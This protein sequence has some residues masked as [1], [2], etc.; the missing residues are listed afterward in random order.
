LGKKAIRNRKSIKS[1]AGSA[2]LATYFQAI[3]L[4]ERKSVLADATNLKNKATLAA[5]HRITDAL[6]SVLYVFPEPQLQKW[7]ACCH[8]TSGKPPIFWWRK[9]IQVSALGCWEWQA[10]HLAEA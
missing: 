1:W 10:E 9:Q 6:R 4:S 2:D 7:C 8:H 3:I 5:V